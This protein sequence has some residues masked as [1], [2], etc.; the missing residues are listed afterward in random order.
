MATTR[1]PL[2]PEQTAQALHAYYTAR[3]QAV[4]YVLSALDGTA[5]DAPALPYPEVL[6]RV[7]DLIAAE[8]DRYATQAEAPP[9]PAVPQA[10]VQEEGKDG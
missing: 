9:A 8:M 6:T 7:Y 1:P 2:D 10:D 5:F 4:R 3:E